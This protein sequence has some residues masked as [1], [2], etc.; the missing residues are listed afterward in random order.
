LKWIFERK[1][2]TLF[3]FINFTRVLLLFRKRK[4]P[5]FPDTSRSKLL[6]PK[7]LENQA[8]IKK[9]LVYPF[10]DL[11]GDNY[12]S[13]AYQKYLLITSTNLEAIAGSEMCRP[14]FLPPSP[15]PLTPLLL[16]TFSSP[17]HKQPCT[18]NNNK[19]DGTTTIPATF[20]PANDAY[21]FVPS[22]S[23]YHNNKGEN[24][25]EIYLNAYANLSSS[26]PVVKTQF[27]PARNGVVGPW[28]FE[29]Y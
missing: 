5:L 3:L 20:Q 22:S 24:E 21:A 29:L 7:T 2:N 6:K 11:L 27:A 9:S 15:F 17:S 23:N 19:T 4:M 1:R 16:A 14:P 12:T 8:N 28:S 10:I 13:F 25:S 18:K 26:V